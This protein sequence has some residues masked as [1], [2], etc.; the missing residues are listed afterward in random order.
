MLNL[1]RLLADHRESGAAASLVPLF[2]W[3]DDHVFLTKAGD[4]GAVLRVQGIDHECLEADA[5]DGLTARLQAA[6]GLWQGGRVYQYLFRRQ[7]REIPHGHYRDP[8]VRAAAL[9][10]IEHFARR[11]RPLYTVDLYYVCLW[12]GPRHDPGILR[13]IGR[14]LREGLAGGRRLAAHLSDDAQI[15]QQRESLDRTHQALL[16][17]LQAFVVQVADFVRAEVLHKR[18]AYAVLGR[19]LNLD[20]LKQQA[21][22]ERLAQGS[23]PYD[24]HADYH[25]CNSHIEAERDHLRIDDYYVRILTLKEPTT[26]TWP[27]I[28]R[29]LQEL[30][31]D[32]HLVSEWRP[33]PNTLTRAR[34][35]R[36][37]HFLNNS[38]VS[39]LS[40]LHPS[41]ATNPSEALVDYAKVEGVQELGRCM[42]LLDQGHHMGEYTLTAVAYARSR[43]EV[44]A[45]VAELVKAFA[46][47]GGALYEERQNQ[48]NA[49]MATLPGNTYFN[50]RGQD[51]LL[52]D[53]H[54]ADGSFLFTLDGGEQRNAHLDGEY[55]AVLETQQGTPYFFNLH[56]GDVAHTLVLGQTGSGKSFLL[57]FLGAHLQK[58]DPVTVVFEL[59]R[60]FESVTRLFG[61]AYVALG[62]P[63]CETTIN[64]FSLE[65]TRE[66]QLFLF[67]F[68]R[69]LLEQAAP[70]LS[71]EDE[72]ELYEALQRLYQLDQDV[73]R[74]RT[75]ADLLPKALSL[76]LHPWVEGG[77]YDYLFDHAADT[78]SFASLQA[79]DFEALANKPEALEP[80]LFYVLHRAT[81]LVCD[82]AATR[83]FKAL[84]CDEAWWSWRHPVIRDY[85]IEA[86]KTWRKKNGAVVLATHSVRDLQDAQLL[87]HLREPCTTKLFLP[88]PGADQELYCQTLQLTAA[89]FELVRTLQPK[90]QFLLKRPGFAKVL[91]LDV[92]QRAYW[93]YTSDAN[94][95]ARRDQVVAEHGLE[96]GLDI[97]ART[98]RSAP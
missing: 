33:L 92:D 44:D 64:P 66:N 8:V 94:D 43:G 30:S 21:Q 38:R 61:G 54:H 27:L 28:F 13:A 2:G 56:V 41:V 52:F 32:Y 35:D 67:G 90:R 42:A 68:V 69:V 97:L 87:D 80:L 60:G 36:Q 91:T 83:R 34:L 63:A 86:L 29:R 93:L 40:E 10:R 26:Q 16:R 81:A 89:E 76:R 45:A 55:L 58:Y 19:L 47:H 23:F 48:L 82:P 65:P 95:R 25:L 31:A 98:P 57:N 71:S 1:K 74:L 39:W 24:L 37:R 4:V 46:Q 62:D 77:R 96:A 5:V 79:F 70:R 49:F 3:L 18:Q 14:A 59:G 9:E 12:H 50:V 15:L 85:L 7:Q 88:N 6:F 51:N 11:R 72:R 22:S 73:R 17:R 20:P 78:L 84:I 75:L 53:F